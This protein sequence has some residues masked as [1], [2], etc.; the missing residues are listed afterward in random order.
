MQTDAA[1]LAQGDEADFC[2]ILLSG[3]CDVLQPK[4]DVLQSVP[5]LRPPATTPP[6]AHS[7]LLLA[8]PTSSCVPDCLLSLCL[9]HFP[10]SFS[11][12]AILL[13]VVPTAQGRLT[14]RSSPHMFTY[15]ERFI[16]LW[17][18]PQSTSV[19]AFASLPGGEVPVVDAVIIKPPPSGSPW[20][21]QP[22]P[23]SF[24]FSKLMRPAVIRPVAAVQSTFSSAPSAYPAAVASVKGAPSKIA[25]SATTSAPSYTAAQWSAGGAVQ[26]AARAGAGADGKEVV[27]AADVKEAPTQVTSAF[28]V[29]SKVA[30]MVRKIKQRAADRTDRVVTTLQVCELHTHSSAGYVVGLRTWTTYTDKPY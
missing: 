20:Q 4:Q 5:P 11:Q 3:A 1:A 17:T 10:T 8:Q 7:G 29:S 28:A 16:A 18:S 13:E 24:D 21:H 9:V 26:G 19:E 22:Q 23:L 14:A 30:L 12:F 25:P 15:I 2:F 27:A 6:H